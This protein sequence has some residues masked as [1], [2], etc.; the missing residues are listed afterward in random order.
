MQLAL[1]ARAW[2]LENPGDLVVGVGISI[3]GQKTTHYVETSASDYTKSIDNIGEK[4]TV[5]HDKYRFLNEDS[6]PQSDPFR[7]WLASRI[8][9]ALNISNNADNG[10]FH[11]IPQGSCKFCKVRNIC[12]V[13]MEASF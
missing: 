4:T 1:Y 9:T 6:S 12:D 5:T 13:R 11:P 2:E 8:S 3:L 7:A 10:Y